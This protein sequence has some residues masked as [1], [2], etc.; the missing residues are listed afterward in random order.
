MRS[1]NRLDTHL[2][3][4]NQFHEKPIR[5][6]YISPTV[7]SLTLICWWW[8]ICQYKMMQK[9]LKMTETVALRE[10]ISYEYEHDMV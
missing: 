2:S 3:L 1:G 10:L 8:L 4:L 6:D 5:L 9:N 7:S